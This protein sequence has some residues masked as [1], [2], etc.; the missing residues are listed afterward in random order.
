MQNDFTFM[1][2]NCLSDNII[3]CLEKIDQGYARYAQM[4]ILTNDV[5][6]KKSVF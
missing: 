6:V 4:R 1:K 5:T 3:V 2:E